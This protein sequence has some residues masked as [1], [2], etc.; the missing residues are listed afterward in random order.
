MTDITKYIVSG[1]TTNVD[2]QDNLA[3]LMDWNEELAYSLASKEGIQ[4]QDGHWQVIHFLRNRYIK[5]GPADSARKLTD[6]LQVEF[7]NQGGSKFLYQ[8]FPNGPVAQA[9]R[10]A[11]LPVP[12]G[13]VDPSFGSVH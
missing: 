6:V 7:A 3:D 1:D 5:S 13:S 10:I 11:G 2:V 12:K 4:L 9:C 8:L